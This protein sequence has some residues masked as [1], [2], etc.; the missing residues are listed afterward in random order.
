MNAPYYGAA[1]LSAA[2]GTKTKTIS[3]LDNSSNTTAV[4]AFYDSSG[5]PNTL[6]AV[7]TALFSGSGTRASDT[8]TFTGL[9][10]PSG[11]KTLHAVRMTSTSA[12]AVIANG[13]VVT[14]GGASFSGNCVL[15][16]QPVSEAVSVTDGRVQVEV[17]AS[18]ALYI[19]L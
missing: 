1:F 3:Q 9:Q 6:L 13:N 16:K 4:Y 15:D 17:S 7:N 2:L 10:L 5:A 8:V 19:T 12:T 11:T 14:M 18:E